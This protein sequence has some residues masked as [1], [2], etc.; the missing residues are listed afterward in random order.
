[1]EVFLDEMKFKD[2]SW[3]GDEKGEF[4]IIRNQ[5]KLKINLIL[6]KATSISTFREAR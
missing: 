1:L 6:D 3:F 2:Y 5:F 4:E